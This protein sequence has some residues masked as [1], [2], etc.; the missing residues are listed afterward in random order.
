VSLPRGLQ[1]TGLPGYTA[2][3]AGQCCERSGGR[4]GGRERERERERERDL[5]KEK[6]IETNGQKLEGS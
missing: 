4:E 1:R 5:K 3:A 2:P 6:R